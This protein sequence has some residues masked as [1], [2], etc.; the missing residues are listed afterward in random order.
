MPKLSIWFGVCFVRV[1]SIFTLLYYTEKGRIIVTFS[2]SLLGLTTVNTE[3]IIS[4]NS[5]V[6][7]GQVVV[8]LVSTDNRQNASSLLEVGK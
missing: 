1:N 5:I 8:Q 6:S 7:E 4:R 3:S 2:V